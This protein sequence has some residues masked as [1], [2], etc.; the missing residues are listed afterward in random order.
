MIEQ[1]HKINF[2]QKI[3]NSSRFIRFGQITYFYSYV[4]DD[5]FRTFTFLVQI[6]IN[7]KMDQGCIKVDDNIDQ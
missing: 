3:L 5:K 2:I 7:H 1:I 4:M 6:C